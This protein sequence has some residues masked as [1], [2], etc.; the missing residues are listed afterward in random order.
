MRVS[1]Y[2]D[3]EKLG[4]TSEF[5]LSD[6][7]KIWY[8]AYLNSTSGPLADIRVRQAL[9][10]A[11]D[12][13]SVNK[14]LMNGKCEPTSQPLQEGAEGHRQ[15]SGGFGYRYDP[16]KARAL[17]ADAGYPNGLTLN[18]ITSGDISK[19]GVALESQLKDVGVTINFRN[20]DFNDALAV[21]QSDQADAF[22]FASNATADSAI[23][24]NDRYL[25]STQRGP[26]PDGFKEKLMQALSLDVGNGSRGALLSELTTMASER[27]MELFVCAPTNAYL[28]SSRMMGF[29]TM[30]SPFAGGPFSLRDVYIAD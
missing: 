29:D 3:A 18:G 25:G 20:T 8:N 2:T 15:E 27:P 17:L 12:R 14:A 19:V 24:L 4:E 22:L 5:D 26:L 16:A 28:H 7:H 11:I 6:L 9:N 23:T 30:A 1:Q 21:W 13:E 10:Y